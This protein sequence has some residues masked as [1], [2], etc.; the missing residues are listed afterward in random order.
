M[1]AL[2]GDLREW[3]MQ[4]VATFVQETGKDVTGR[5][6]EDTRRF[7]SELKQVPPGCYWP[8]FALAGMDRGDPEKVE[9]GLR[10]GEA[11][12]R[13]VVNRLERVCDAVEEEL[14]RQTL[15][16][17]ATYIRDYLDAN[18]CNADEREAIAEELECYYANRS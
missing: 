2:V 18:L 17:E 10:P 15:S 6:L 1:K 4:E 16:P 11:F 7:V 12:L 13:A 9:F 3:R 8:I 5:C 14:R